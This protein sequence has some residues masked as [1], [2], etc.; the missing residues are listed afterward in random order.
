MSV[1]QT[2]CANSVNKVIFNFLGARFW[3]PMLVYWYENCSGYVTD[4][5]IDNEAGDE[6]DND[7]G[8][9]N[10]GGSDDEKLGDDGG[11]NDDDDEDAVIYHHIQEFCE[12]LGSCLST[13]RKTY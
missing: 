7:D 12:F 1:I 6:K 10:D 4:G 11:T 9:T 8:D 2:D 13:S 3:T 5:D